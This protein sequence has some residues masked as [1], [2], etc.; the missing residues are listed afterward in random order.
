MAWSSTVQELVVVV[1]LKA[2]VLVNLS[3]D[4]PTNT[5]SLLQT[6]K[7]VFWTG[8]IKKI[9]S[10][11]QLLHGCKELKIK[12]VGQT[13]KKTGGLACF[14]NTKIKFSTLKQ[15]SLVINPMDYL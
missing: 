10:R 15:P 13:Y 11:S 4:Y 12:R 2:W 14:V 7:L 9:S 5:S 8:P 3:P 1:V 6:N